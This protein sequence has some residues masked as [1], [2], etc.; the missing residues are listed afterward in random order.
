MLF[1]SFY[2]PS[3]ALFRCS[4]S[5]DNCRSNSQTFHFLSFQ[6]CPILSRSDVDRRCR[7]TA[8]CWSSHRSFRATGCRRPATFPPSGQMEFH[9]LLSKRN[10]ENYVR[11]QNILQTIDG[12]DT[13]S[14]PCT[15]SRC[16]SIRPLYRIDWLNASQ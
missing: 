16:C 6:N 11:N 1:L 13:E 9:L 5:Q 2:K 12:S 7:S 15:N 10:P 8:F 3:R 4:F 14:A